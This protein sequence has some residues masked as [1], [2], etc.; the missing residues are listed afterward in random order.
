MGVELGEHLDYAPARVRAPARAHR[1]A[2]HGLARGRPRHADRR[3]RAR[4]RQAAS[5]RSGSRCRT[6]TTASRSRRSPARS[7]RTSRRCCARR[8]SSFDDAA[9]SPSG[10]TS[11]SWAACA[12]H[13]GVSTVANSSRWPMGIPRLRMPGGAP[14]RSTLKLAEA[15]LEFVG[16]RRRRLEPGHDR[17]GPR[18][19]ARRMDLAA[20][21]AGLHGHG[22]RQR[23]H[24]RGPPRQRAGEAPARRRLP[25]PPARAGGTGWCATWWRAP[26]ASPPWRAMDRPGM[27]HGERSST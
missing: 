26:R 4:A 11:S 24:G 9:G 2:P 7:R 27:V 8:A 20:R 6:P 16:A 13:V 10:C 18:R 21:A 5:P 12:C 3:G 25:L 19:R 14:S 15:L 17:R 23:P 22:G 1:R